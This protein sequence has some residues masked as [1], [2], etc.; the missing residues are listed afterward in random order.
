MKLNIPILFLVFNRIDTTKQVFQK[1]R[2]VKPKILYIASDGPRNNR[3]GEYEKVKNVRDFI[4]KSIDWDCEIKTLF[5]DKNLG[6]GKAVSCAITW[7]FKNEE[8]GIILEDDCLPSLSFFIYCEELLLKYKDNPIIW[9]IAGNNPLTE[10][11]SKYSY[12][13]ARVQHCW[14]W[15]SWR[16][17]WNY[18]NFDIIDLDK[19]CNEGINKIFTRK[20]DKRYWINIFNKMYNHEIDTWDYQWAY[21][22]MKNN[23]ICINPTKNLIKNIG[24]GEDATHTTY[25]DDAYNKQKY[26]DIYNNTNEVE[27]NLIHPKYIKINNNL[28][29]KINKVTFGIKNDSLIKIILKKYLNNNIYNKLKLI[30]KVFN[31]NRK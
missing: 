28:I 7:F 24:F 5:H 25:T 8:M 23:G 17:A 20:E 30:M 26:Y 13:F 2:L 31:K 10:I 14:G 19:F 29:N 16:R 3:E 11:K 22:I 21:T 6:C 1:I 12:Y 4:I 18:Y 9:H 15:A 27:H